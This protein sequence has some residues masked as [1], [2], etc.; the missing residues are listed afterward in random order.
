MMQKLQRKW[1]PRFFRLAAIK[2][3][4]RGNGNVKTHRN[5]IPKITQN[6]P[7]WGYKTSVTLLTYRI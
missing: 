6:V 3:M 1:F 2:W 5:H 4:S 7:V